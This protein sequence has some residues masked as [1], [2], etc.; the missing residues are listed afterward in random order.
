MPKFSPE[1]EIRIASALEAY[2][3]SDK[4]NIKALAREF[5]VSYGQLYGRVK[6]RVSPKGHTGPNRALDPE[7]EA[8]LIHWI[9]LLDN[10]H[11]SPTALMVLQCAN[12]IIHRHNPQRPSL[13]KNWAYDFIKRLPPRLNFNVIKQKPKEGD[14]MAAEDPG[15]LTC[16]YERLE[17]FIKNKNLQPRDIYNFDE[18][19]FKIGEGKTQKVISSC[20]TSYVATGGPAENITAVECIAA[21]GWLMPPWFLVQGKNHMENWYHT[22]NLPS[23]YT[24]VPT[25]TGWITNTAAFQWLHAFHECTKNRVSRGGFRLLLMDNHGS[26][27]THEFLQFCDRH[28]IIAYCFIPHTTH[29]CQPLDSRPFQVLKDYYKKNNNTVVQWGGSVSSKTDFFREID[30]VRKQALTTRTIKSGFAACGIYPFNIQKVLD[31]LQEAL[32][33]VPDLQIFDGEDRD[34]TPP[35]SSSIT[36]SPPQ[37]LEKL[38][39]S[40]SKLQSDL[41]GVKDQID[42]INPKIRLRTGLICRGSLIQANLAAQYA[43]DNARMLTHKA[44]LGVRKTKRQI[45]MGGPLTVLDANRHIKVRGDAES[46]AT[47]RQ[48]KKQAKAAAA[49]VA[50]ISTTPGAGT[51]ATGQNDALTTQ[52]GVGNLFFIDSTGVC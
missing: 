30:A 27:L 32:P 5:D 42:T 17:L 26:H 39:R 18:S 52:E 11:A 23:D 9:T 22:T 3:T 37:T 33:P 47:V 12:Q 41:Q 34:Q 51:D 6:G 1:V 48:A 36:N 8:A 21:D 16:W 31:P 49:T 24:L 10:A 13:H 20:T 4:P 7:Q 35:L 25:P 28:H 19:G 14:R 40:I 2:R 44:Y 50:S 29:I 43:D 38:S 45:K 15:L 46:T